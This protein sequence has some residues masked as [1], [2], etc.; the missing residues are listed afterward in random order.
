MRRSMV[1]FLVALVLVPAAAGAVE[2][3]TIAVNRGAAGVTLGMTRTTVVAK[4][5]KPLYQN[6]N[7]YMQ[8]SRRNLFDVYLN[9]ATR[10]VRLIGISGPRFCTGWGL[11]MDAK[12]GLA[13]LKAHYGGALRRV[14]QETGQPT[15]IV[16]GR[17]LGRRV[18][19]SFDAGP[20]GAII[21]I[22][23]GYCPPLPTECG[24]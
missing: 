18:F 7:C 22:F 24:K 15:W 8:Y 17:Y 14:V 13:K 12:G 5:G 21:Q 9:T 16:R 4:L 3:G 20:G 11:C 1:A 19:T 23:I 6:A 10:R 2:R